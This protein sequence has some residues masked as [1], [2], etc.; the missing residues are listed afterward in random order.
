[1]YGIPSDLMGEV[2]PGS[3]VLV[4][5]RNRSLR[6]FVL[7]V[8]SGEPRVGLRQIKALKGGAVDDRV[9]SIARWA[10]EYYVAPIGEVLKAAVPNP[11]ARVR[12][13]AG[14]EE[15]S[16]VPESGLSLKP[17]SQQNAVLKTIGEGLERGDFEVFLLQGVTGSGKTFIYCKAA[18]RVI[19]DGGSC[20]VLVPEISMSTQLVDRFRE[21]FGDEVV[22]S[23]SGLSASERYQ[24]WKKAGS[25]EA[26]VVVGARSAVFSPLVNL[27]LI[28]VDEEHEPSFKQS[29]VPRYNARDV[30]VKRGQL[31]GSLVL[32]GTATP[33]LESYNNA[34]TGKYKM[35]R[36]PCRIDSRPLASVQLVDLKRRPG[37]G[38]GGPTKAEAGANSAGGEAA[39]RPDAA[40]V[41]AKP[42]SSEVASKPAGA[43][44]AAAT[45]ASWLFSE[46]LKTKMTERLANREQV[47]LFINRRGHSTFVQCRDCGG[48]FRCP[49]CEVTL[50]YH[51]DPH[52]LFCHYCGYTAGSANECPKCGGSNFWFGGVGTQKVENEIKRMFP[53]V[54]VLR[55]DVDSTRR[56]GSQRS[57]V[58]T[59]SSGEALVLLGTQ[60]VAKGFDFP[61][62]TLVGV[63]YADTQLNLPDFRASE[64]TFQLLT[65][66]AGRAGR[67][68]LPGEVIIQTFLPEHPSLKAAARQDFDLFCE[69]ELSDRRELFF[70][71]FS[72]LIDVSFAAADENEVIQ[73]SASV[74]RGLER[75]L[76]EEGIT[77]VDVMGPAPYPIARMRNKSRWHITLRG[78]SLPE[79]RRGLVALRRIAERERPGSLAVGLDIDPLQLM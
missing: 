73:C 60:M 24:S 61:G 37:G 2:R 16:T 14:R 19:A 51:S 22:I 69:G 57:M 5:F 32:L 1:V 72:R 43:E 30:A 76:R 66:V 52:R 9:M 78:K 41:A 77:S 63:I 36:L 75:W 49:R 46:T 28:I 42:G 54:G 11:V 40:E 27:K 13:P 58:E 53:E 10:A 71:P 17:N 64:R 6:G 7:E 79:L 38:T 20:L 56:K 31:E 29:D 67:G 65:Q 74:K 50:T 18:A 8:F 45:D 23:H 12:L 35:L 47:I 3:Q 25:G 55:M 62:V 21:F 33:S 48:S 68:R 39:P 44:A 34:R 59:F 70:P 26:K 15:R 4:P